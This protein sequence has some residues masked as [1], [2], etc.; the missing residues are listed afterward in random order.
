VA[1]FTAKGAA[2]EGLVAASMLPSESGF[3][4]VGNNQ[5][6][7]FGLIEVYAICA[8]S[9]SYEYVEREETAPDGSQLGVAAPCPNG[10]KVTAGGVDPDSTSTSVE[11]A[12][13]TPYRDGGQLP[14]DGWQGT[15]NNNNTG[16][17]VDFSTWAVCRD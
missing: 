7:D 14:D 13:V 17:G 8:N 10:T 2:N 15:V 12:R 4:A 16:A 9:G 11:V 6:G 3:F 1:L 5:T